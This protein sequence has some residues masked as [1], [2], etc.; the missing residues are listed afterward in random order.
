MI[1]LIIRLIYQSIFYIGGVQ[2]LYILFNDLSLHVEL[3][4]THL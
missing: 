1:A 3:I 4:R 2:I